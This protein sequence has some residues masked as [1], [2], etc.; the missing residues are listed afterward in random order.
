VIAA[1]ACLQMPIGTIL[2]VW[3]IVTLSKPQVKE[4]FT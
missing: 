1:I 3:T 2:G 4:L